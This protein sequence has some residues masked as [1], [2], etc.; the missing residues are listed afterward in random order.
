MGDAKPTTSAAPSGG[1]NAVDPA[2]SIVGWHRQ[3]DGVMTERV[4]A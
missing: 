3:V 4:W 2:L 1:V